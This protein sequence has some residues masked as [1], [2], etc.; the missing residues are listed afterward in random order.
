MK[1]I[2]GITTVFGLALFLLFATVSI[3]PATEAGPFYVGAFGG[4]VIPRDLEVEIDG[5]GSEEIEVNLDNS[6]AVG[7]KFGYIFPQVNWLAAELEYTYLADQDFDE[8]EAIDDMS[9]RLSGDF[10]AHNIMANLLCRY[11]EGKIH[12]YVGLGLGISMANFEADGTLTIGQDVYR[13]SAD[14]DDTSWAFQV[15]AGVSYEISPSWSADIAYKYFYSEYEIDDLDIDVKNNLITAGLTY[16]FGGTK[17]QIVP[18]PPPTPEPIP[19][20]EPDT[21]GDGVIDKLDK[22]PDTPA[23]VK[24]DEVGCPLDT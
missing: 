23:G 22:C 16:Y 20:V 4:W 3:A 12:P 6:W 14:E 17:K 15:I 9:A 21:D 5:F 19:V 13:D 7:A 24:V 8:Y 10:S 1:R 11:P 18:P 2:R